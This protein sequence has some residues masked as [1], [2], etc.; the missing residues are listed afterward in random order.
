MSKEIKP[1]VID[2]KAQENESRRIGLQ[3]KLAEPVRKAVLD[4]SCQSA[5]LKSRTNSNGEPL[6]A[7]RFEDAAQ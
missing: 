2:P 5:A 7:P 3:Q 1:S 6:A 4:K